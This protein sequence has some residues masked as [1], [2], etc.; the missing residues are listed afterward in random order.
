MEMAVLFIDHHHHLPLT[1]PPKKKQIVL[2]SLMIGCHY[3]F[4]TC[5]VQIG[6]KILFYGV[7]LI[8]QV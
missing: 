1:P 6:V 8:L 4:I 5:L 7:F 3:N 2:N